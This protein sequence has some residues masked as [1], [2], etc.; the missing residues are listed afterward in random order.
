MLKRQSKKGGESMTKKVIKGRSYDKE[1]INQLEWLKEKGVWDKN[2]RT[3]YEDGN[4]AYSKRGFDHTI[5]INKGTIPVMFSKR[6]YFKD[7]VKELL[8]IW[9]QRSNKV[10]D[11]QEMGSKVWNEWEKEDG[12]IGNAYGAQL[13]REVDDTG[14]NQVD[15][16]IHKLKT[17]RD[18]RR[19]IVTLWD[20][21]S[22]HEMALKPCVYETQWVVLD[23]ELYL[24]VISRSTDS[25]L[26]EPYNI[27]QYWVLLQL[28]AHETG[29][30]PGGLA[31]SMAIPHYYDRHET[32][33]ERQIEYYNKNK[34][35]IDN[36]EVV[37]GI[38]LSK[39]FYGF[40]A[41]DIK[42]KDYAQRDDIPKRKFEIAI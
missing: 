13:A 1:Y 38:D 30:E 21:S 19:H 6:L 28:I 37:V 8:W 18:S 36:E 32:E 34:D 3:V 22:G 14:M 29:L 10:S 15:N 41:D 39:G 42:I 26:G 25:S 4:K 16:L 24:K 17:D 33:I 40:T 27:F 11:L 20:I 31:F 7:A 12:T 35:R 23:N 2:P 9:Q 5:L